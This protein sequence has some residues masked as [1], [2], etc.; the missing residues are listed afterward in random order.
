ML[1]GLAS[2]LVEGQF[3]EDGQDAQTQEKTICFH[4]KRMLGAFVAIGVLTT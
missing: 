3:A 4:L 2:L 1:H